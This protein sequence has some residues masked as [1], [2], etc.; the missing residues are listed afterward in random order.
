M[1]VDIGVNIGVHSLFMAV[2]G[3]RIF[4]VDPYEENLLHVSLYKHL[5]ERCRHSFESSNILTLLKIH[6]YPT[7]YVYNSINI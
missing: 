4:G 2:N 7:L 5:L 6:N 3:I 1:F